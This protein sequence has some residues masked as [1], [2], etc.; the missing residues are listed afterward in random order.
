MSRVQLPEIT[1]D[2]VTLEYNYAIRDKILYCRPPEDLRIRMLD[3]SNYCKN[4]TNTEQ[5]QNMRMQLAGDISREIPILFDHDKQLEKDF[6]N[7][8][9]EAL[10][11]FLFD[12]PVLDITLYKA[13]VNYMKKYEYNPL[14][15]HPN[16]KISLVWYLDYPEEIRQ[17]HQQQ[18]NDFDENRSRGMV[19][20][21]SNFSHDHMTMNPK[22]GDMFLFHATHKHAVYPFY[23]DNTR[24]SMSCNIS[25]IFVRSVMGSKEEVF[26]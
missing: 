3:F 2:M 10:S 18:L 20:F 22:T 4:I 8:L 13:W 17:E 1:D 19:Y 23:T 6:T 16:A 14:H 21:S 24:I 15:Q 7:Y 12:S 25:N 5:K 9:I 11:K 26:L